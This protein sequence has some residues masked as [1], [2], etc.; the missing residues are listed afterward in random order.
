MQHLKPYENYA[1]IV[2]FSIA[3]LLTASGLYPLIAGLDP[4]VLERNTGVTIEQLDAFD[5]DLAVFITGLERL[6]GIAAVTGSALAAAVS[7]IARRGN[8]GRGTWYA[9]WLFPA[10]LLGSAGIFM[11]GE[12]AGLGEFYGGAGL[13]AGVAHALSYRRFA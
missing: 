11:S 5:P 8:S 3:V 12:G 1:W 2:F 6:I 9:L 7:W 4:E 10:M 13:L